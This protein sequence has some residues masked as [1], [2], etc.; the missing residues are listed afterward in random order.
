MLLVGVV[1]A[2][3][4]MRAALASVS[5]LAGEIGG[6]FGLSSAAVSLVTSV[7]VLFL[8]AG[9]L[10]A[11]GSAA[12]S[13]PNG[14]CSPRCCSSRPASPCAYCPRSPRSTAAGCWSAPPSR[15]ST[16]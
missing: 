8:G 12:A 9:A 11:P 5:P 6:A 13:A 7:P 3:V 4:N 2:S 10:V 15:C 14:C 1:L 16:C